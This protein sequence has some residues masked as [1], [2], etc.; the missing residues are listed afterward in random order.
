MERVNNRGTLRLVQ[1][2]AKAGAQTQRDREGTEA[3]RQ[4][5][6]EASKRLDLGKYLHPGYHAPRWT[7]GQLAL[8]GTLADADVARRIGRTLGA[9]RIKRE[10]LGIP[11]PQAAAY[12]MAEELALLGTATDTE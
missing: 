12:W 10:A 2:N 9:V 11:N 8:L 7:A 5:K 1:A 4:A 3:E 6:R